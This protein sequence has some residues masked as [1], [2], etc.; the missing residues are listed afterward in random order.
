MPNARSKVRNARMLWVRESE[1]GVPDLGAVEAV[2]QLLAQAANGGS[3]SLVFESS[4]SSAISGGDV[5]GVYRSDKDDLE[6]YKT[7]S[8]SSETV[9]LIGGTPVVFRREAGYSAQVYTSPAG[10]KRVP[11][12][13]G[14]TLSP[15]IPL[16]KSEEITGNKGVQDARPDIVRVSGDINLQIGVANSGALLRDC[17]NGVYYQDAP[18][19][20]PAE[21]GA[22]NGAHSAGASSIVVAAVDEGWA[23]GNVLKINDGK[24]SEL[25]KIHTTWDGNATT[26]PLD[27]TTKLMYAHVTTT[28]VEKVTT[29]YTHIVERGDS[30]PSNTVILQFADSGAVCVY[31]GVKVNLFNLTVNPLNGLMNLSLSVIGKAP[32]IMDEYIFGA[33][34]TF[35][36]KPLTNWEAFIRQDGAVLPRVQEYTVTIDNQLEADGFE[37]GSRFVG[38]ID[39]DKGD[40]TGSFNYKFYDNARIK[41]IYFEEERALEFISRYKGGN[42]QGEGF[43]VIYPRVLFGG[44]GFPQIPASG[45]IGGTQQIQAMYDE[46]AGTDVK[47]RITDTNIRLAA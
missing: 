44:S 31:R 29:P 40:A 30:V 37:N 20:S 38:S 35:P 39:E 4:V 32:Q 46:T 5:I 25:V 11:G 17:L 45:F 43:D 18:K 15:D 7:S 34:T 33:P 14:T 27:P 41:D 13:I 26:I 24:K 19:V 3:T 12:F 6:F 36:H 21:D 16:L 23:V 10:L 47:L 8:V 22:L 1:L 2:S 28:P 9:T 42:S